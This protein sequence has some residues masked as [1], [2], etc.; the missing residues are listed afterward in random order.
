MSKEKTEHSK[1]TSPY[2]SG[3][4]TAAAHLVEIIMERQAKKEKKVLGPKFWSDPLWAKPFRFQMTH[5]HKLLKKYSVVAICNA[6]KNPKAKNVV[7]LGA[8]FILEPLILIE[9]ARL[10]SRSELQA[11]VVQTD[12]KPR[13]QEPKRG[14][15]GRLD[16][17]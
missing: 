3:F 8:L 16:D 12:E 1:F 17:D 9:Q 2:T 14:L 11:D 10:E 5:A 7:S 15:L 13:P 4:V 6:L